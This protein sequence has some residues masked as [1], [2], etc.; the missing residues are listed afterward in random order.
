MRPVA[1]VEI[2]YV[3]GWLGARGKHALRESWELAVEAPGSFDGY[4]YEHRYGVLEPAGV[5]RYRLTRVDRGSGWEF[6]LMEG[7]T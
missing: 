7:D 2:P 4:V 1:E 3:G 5:E 6:R